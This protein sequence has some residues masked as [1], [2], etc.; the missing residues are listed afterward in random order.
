MLHHPR[1]E[2]VHYPE[3][4]ANE[5]KQQQGGKGQGYYVP[6][7]CRRPV[8]VQ[9]VVQVYQHLQQ[10]GKKQPTHGN[11]S[12]NR[13]AHHQ[14]KGNNGKRYGQNKANDIVFGGCMARSHL[15]VMCV[16][17]ISIAFNY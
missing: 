4:S 3:R 13:M 14:R 15:L 5:D 2:G 1:V 9:K 8:E 7:C 12:A 6:A 10:G 11:R 16:T 17:H